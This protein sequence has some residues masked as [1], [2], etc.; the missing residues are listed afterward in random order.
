MGGQERFVVAA[1]IELLEARLGSGL[2]DKQ[3]AATADALLA[4][5]RERLTD[6]EQNRPVNDR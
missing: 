6:L 1:N 3:Q 2:L 4:K 5:Y